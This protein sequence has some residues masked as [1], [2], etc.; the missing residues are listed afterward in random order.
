MMQRHGVEHTAQPENDVAP[1][2][3]T[4]RTMV[5]LSHARTQ[6]GLLGIPVRNAKAR[7]AIENAK[8]TLPQSFVGMD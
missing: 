8:L 2:F 3:P 6:L 5:E 4:R 1:A 7:E